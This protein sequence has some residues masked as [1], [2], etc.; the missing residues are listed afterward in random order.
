MRRPY[1]LALLADALLAAGSIDDGLAAVDEA[2]ALIESSGEC[3]WQAETLRLKGML[4]LEHGANADAVAT[5][6]RDAIAV[7]R[8]QESKLLELRAAT[9]LARLTLDHA[10]PEDARDLLAPVLDWFTEGF[11]APDLRAAKA[12]LDGL[13]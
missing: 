2:E 6:F 7:A 11:D 10:K 4:T 12:F 5:H 9:S 8:H 3:R 1:F 13:R